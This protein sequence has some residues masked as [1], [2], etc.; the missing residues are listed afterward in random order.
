MWSSGD[1]LGHRGCFS[2]F[3]LETRNVCVK[4]LLLESWFLVLMGMYGCVC[5][6]RYN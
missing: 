5:V 2:L 1:G 6:S 4:V 3:E